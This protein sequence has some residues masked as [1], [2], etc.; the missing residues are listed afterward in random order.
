MV[1]RVV[2]P[3]G[4]WYAHRYPTQED[5]LYIVESLR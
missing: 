1:M 5:E 2:T 4:R 3:D